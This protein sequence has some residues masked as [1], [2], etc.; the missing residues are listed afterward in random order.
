MKLSV[1]KK[2]WA[3][4]LSILIFLMTIGFFYLWIITD[5][6]K[7]Y[8]F[9]L[10]D[11]VKK[12]NLVDEMI[13]KQQA[14]SN[15]VRG[16]IIYKDSTYLENRVVKNE[17]FEEAYEN[18][19][20]T[21]TS[22]EDIELLEE[23]H[24]AKLEYMELAEEI[25]ISMQ[26]GDSAKDL[27][28]T[29]KTDK[30][31]VL[32]KTILEKAEKLSDNQNAYLQE[33]REDL[34][35]KVKDMER[36]IVLL[37]I[38]GFILSI[39]LPIVL[40]RSISRPVRKLT[41]AI[42]QVAGGNL[43]IEE[44]RIRNKDEIGEM[45]GAFNKMVAELKAIVLNMRDSS[46][47][48]A[49]QAEQMSASSEESLASSEMVATTAEENMRGTARQV[50]IVE[51]SVNS[52]NEMAAAIEQ[53]TESNVEMLASAESV[54]ALVQQGS[55]IIDDVTT[56]MNNINTTI[57]ES[58]SI[59]EVMSKHS[60]EIQRVTTL[61]TDI[62]EQTNLLALNAAI[63]AARAGENGKGF[64]V[65]ADE[66]RKLA[67]QSKISASE[68]EKMVKL[69][70]E[71]TEKGVES[72]NIG[73]K[74]AEDGLS[75]SANSLQVFNHIKS[76]VGGV[77]EQIESVS[78]AI[79]EIQA[80]TKDVAAGANAI[81]EIAVTSAERANDTSAAT[82]EQHAATEQISEG[83]QSLATLA[84]SLKMEVNHFKI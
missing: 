74:K 43:Q 1:S 9:L 70:E 72:I 31:S 75:A 26:Q 44:I 71:A 4:F 22:Q 11:R 41:E 61:I 40:S 10:D 2:L 57:N 77:S 73:S 52:M 29:E 60:S 79:E 30:A 55:N 33:T 51:N 47:Q 66:V 46:S 6:N 82:E 23:I 48:L 80:M 84:E 63:E 65:V 69:I 37:I 17:M 49:V 53:I 68:I 45:A 13:N 14:V 54:N 20:K 81:K 25:I 16:Y 12:I 38:F 7:Q 39:I 58:A 5:L 35:D 21:F 76:A 78:S 42:G 8:T 50:T 18:L 3:G 59:M 19:G 36:I 28:I 62:S 24:N 67:E 83:A 64:A 27:D 32:E 15:D 34:N 56:Q